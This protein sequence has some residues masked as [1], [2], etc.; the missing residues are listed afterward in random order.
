[1]SSG[2]SSSES[3]RAAGQPAGEGAGREERGLDQL[4][5]LWRRNR[6]NKSGTRVW[7]G[8]RQ[9]TEG[10]GCSPGVMWSFPNTGR[11]GE[12]GGRGG[13][14][15]KTVGVQTQPH[16]SGLLV[17]CGR[18]LTPL[19]IGHLLQAG[20]QLSHVLQQFLEVGRSMRG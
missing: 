18:V 5:L 15:H 13:G 14:G 2:D 11:G 17:L 12:L 7:E 9:N 6:V 10:R 19:L 20:L 4:W 3:V 16:G 8:R 1:M